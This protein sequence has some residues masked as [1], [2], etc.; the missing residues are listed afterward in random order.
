MEI[1]ISNTLFTG[2]VLEHLPKIDSTNNYAKQMLTKSNPIDGTVILADEQFAGRS[3]TGNICQSE[4]HKNL[5]FSIIYQTSFLKATEQF[6][7]NMAI[8]LGI[9]NA[10]C[11]L[12]SMQHDDNCLLPTKILP[13]KIKWPN[14][15]YVENQKI[16]GILIENTIVGMHLKYS[17]IGIGLNVNQQHFSDT[18]NATSLSLILKKEMNKSD[19][20]NKILAS[21]EKYFLLLKERKFERLKSEYLEN[22]FRYGVFSKFKKKMKFLMEKLLML[23]ITEIW[24]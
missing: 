12:L 2:K 22:L 8:S 23:M 16:A 14:D 9:K 17:V 1:I 5:T 24:F 7:L 21:I 18:I 19:V 3:Q 6:W 13:T 20:L 11:S 10:V 15:I 4:A